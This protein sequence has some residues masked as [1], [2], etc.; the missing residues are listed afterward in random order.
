MLWA[1]TSGSVSSR[2]LPFTSTGGSIG[3]SQSDTYIGG[4]A[5]ITDKSAI[6]ASTIRKQVT[7]S[8]VSN[9]SVWRGLVATFARRRAEPTKRALRERYGSRQNPAALETRVA[10]SY[11]A[12]SPRPYVTG[13]A[14]DEESRS[15]S[16]ALHS[17]LVV[18]VR[19]RRVPIGIDVG[20]LL[21][22]PEN[23]NH[24]H[25]FVDENGTRPTAGK[26]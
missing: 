14:V 25:Q 21:L 17:G 15:R 7:S 1:P 5:G 2:R 3:I 18:D 6:Q 9:H 24:L 20:V 8:R 13:N 10:E 22:P 16:L 4:F 23:G 26:H 19:V 11:Y 12:K